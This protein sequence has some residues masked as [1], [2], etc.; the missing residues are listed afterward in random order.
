[1]TEPIFRIQDTKRSQLGRIISIFNRHSLLFLAIP[2]VLSAYTHLR[3]PVGFP[4]FHID[5]GHYLRK[6]MYVLEG[7]GLQE[8]S[9]EVLSR[10]RQIYTH[11]YFSQIFL[12]GVFSLLGYPDS[13]NPTAGDVHSIEMLWLVP[14]V[15]MGLQL[16]ILFLYLR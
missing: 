3:N 1:M 5:E 2:L 7:N 15:L 9:E 12:A 6:A 14:R 4:T 16:L 8:G 10:F 13:L 11:P